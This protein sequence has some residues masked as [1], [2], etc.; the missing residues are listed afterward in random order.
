MINKRAEGLLASED[1]EDGQ[2]DIVVVLIMSSS[3]FFKHYPLVVWSYPPAGDIV[4]TWIIS[5]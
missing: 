1:A 2:P 3:E 4:T 5:G